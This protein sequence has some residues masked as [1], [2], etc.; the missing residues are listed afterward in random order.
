MIVGI[1]HA[2]GVIVLLVLL[3]LQ[4]RLAALDLTLITWLRITIVL[5]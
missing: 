2:L 4:L 1:V 5:A 3:L